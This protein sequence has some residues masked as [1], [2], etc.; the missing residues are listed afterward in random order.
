MKLIELLRHIDFMSEVR[1]YLVE[2]LNDIP[3]FTGNVLEVP[4]H[5][6]DMNLAEDPN[7]EAI[8]MDV[9]RD[10]DGRNHMY[11]DI[12]LTEKDIPD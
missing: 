9:V 10:K 12:W 11:I 7:F 2:D 4:W 6:A 1:L 5:Y 3:A 8:A